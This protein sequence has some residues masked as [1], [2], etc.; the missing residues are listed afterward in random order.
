MCTDVQMRALETEEE[1]PAEEEAVE[2]EEEEEEEEL[3]L[4]AAVK[5]TLRR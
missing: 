1:V 3:T 4:D 2:E 5:Q